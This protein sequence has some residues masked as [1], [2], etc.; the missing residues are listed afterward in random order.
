M[1]ILAAQPDSTEQRSDAATGRGGPKGG[2]GPVRLL[3]R[4]LPGS[5]PPSL[6]PGGAAPQKCLRT[7]R[8]IIATVKISFAFCLLF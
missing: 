4:S 6:R 8:A 5:P 2:A 1:F 3:R 7:F